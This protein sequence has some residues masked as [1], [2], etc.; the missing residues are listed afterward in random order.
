MRIE[1][2]R[3][4]VRT[5]CE[6]D[7]DALYQIK[8]DPQVLE[9]D[10]TLL[11]RDAAKD[12]MITYIRDFIRMEDEG[13]RDT[14]RCYAIEEKA[15]GTVVGC[16]TF[17]L[18]QI[19]QEYEMGWMMRGEYTKKGYASEAAAAFSNEVLV[20]YGIDYMIV[21]MDTDN[22]ASYRTAEKS[23]FK[24]FEKRTVYD[25]HYNRYCDDYY[26]FRKYS[27]VSKMTERFYG[28]KPYDGRKS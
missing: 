14:W 7:A 13:D 6:D 18:Y 17:S 20:K 27:P 24:L 12:E 15:S 3:L 23:G 5:F 22:P 1:T 4:I 9:F 10:P 16:L 19:L 25:Y 8:T 28:D 11:K 21:F 26:Y 2:E